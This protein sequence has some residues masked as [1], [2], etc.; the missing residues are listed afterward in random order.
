MITSSGMWR[1]VAWRKFSNDSIYRAASILR[2]LEAASVPACRAGKIRVRNTDH[3]RKDSAS[4]LIWD[5]GT[6]KSCVK[7]TREETVSFPDFFAQLALTY[8]ITYSMEQSPSWE[9][10]R[11]SA[12]QEIPTFRG[13]RR[14]IT[15]FTSARH[16]SLTWASSI[17]SMLPQPT[18]WRSILILSCHLRLRL[19]SGLLQEG[20][21]FW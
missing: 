10:Y 8:L 1:S 15:S 11:F 18:S 14:F 5:G 20:V 2:V 9:A 17:Q 21:R 4:E 7:V 3:E 19:P 13:T 16:R 6:K 12:S